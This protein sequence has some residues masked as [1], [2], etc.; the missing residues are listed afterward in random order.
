MS[1]YSLSGENK[2][3]FNIN[4]ENYNSYHIHFF[5]L[6]CFSF[7]HFLSIENCVLPLSQK[8]QPKFFYYFFLDYKIF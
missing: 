5:F 3:K 1:I 4:E 8:R 2:N 6:F 7:E